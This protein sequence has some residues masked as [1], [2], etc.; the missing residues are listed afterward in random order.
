MLGQWCEFRVTERQTRGLIWALLR[1]VMESLAQIRESERR[2][3]QGQ[4]EV[5]LS[6]ILILGKC[7][8]V[9]TIMPG[10]W[11]NQV[12][13]EWVVLEKDCVTQR[14]CCWCGLTQV[15][16]PTVFSVLGLSTR[17]TNGGTWQC[18]P[19]DAESGWTSPHFPVPV[20]RPFFIHGNPHI[21]IFNQF[22]NLLHFVL[23]KVQLLSLWM[24]FLS[25]KK[26]HSILNSTKT[27]KKMFCAKEREELEKESA[28]AVK[29]GCWYKYS[30]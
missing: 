9:R 13:K 27:N 25:P 19:L 29:E 12:M 2:W 17:L 26:W 22:L 6:A 7:E 11:E 28:K 20:S 4:L 24:N 14:W 5:S 8:G 23:S 21:F 1:G 15:P 30:P 3:R 10:K 18:K 16:S